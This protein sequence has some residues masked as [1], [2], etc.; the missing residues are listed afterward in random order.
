MQH[1]SQS[2]SSFIIRHLI[3]LVIIIAV[4]V[5]LYSLTADLSVVTTGA[6]LLVLAHVIA[7]GVIVYGGR[8]FFGRMIRKFH[9]APDTHSHD[10]SQPHTH[11]FETEGAT[12]SWA[13]LYDVFV[14]FVVMGQYQIMMESAVKLANIKSGEQV[15]EIGCGTGN[16]ALA[17]KKAYPSATI[18]GTDAA[19]EMIDRAR[20]KAV[21]QGLEIEFS[22]GLAERIDVPDNTYDLVM[23]S[24]MIHHLPDNLREQ[25]FTEVYRVLKPGGRLLIVDFEPPQN[26]I[27]RA[28]L[29]L[30]PVRPMLQIDNNRILPL[31]EAAGFTSIEKDM[32]DAKIAMYISATKPTV[33]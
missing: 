8:S 31:L 9:G 7:V 14:R 6:I 1:H 16:L 25:A 27:T 29:S 20:Q 26:P 33:F 32:T 5:G 15:L 19:A 28:I 18:H 3:L 23:N 11:D 12:I 4:G 17:A 30:T 10:E 22:Q 13:N 24:L 2:H 21:D